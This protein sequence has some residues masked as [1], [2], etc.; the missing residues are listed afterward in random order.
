MNGRR[1]VV[2]GANTGL[3]LATAS[4]LAGSGVVVVLAGRN[5]GKLEA[6]AET[7]RRRTPAAQLSVGLLDLA[8]LSSVG[9]FAARQRDAGPLD[10]LV[11]NAGLMLVPHRE[12]TADGFELQMGVNHLG[13]FALTRELWPALS[14][15][16]G[17]VVSLSSI[18][19]RMAG[20]FDPGMGEIGPYAPFANYA[21]SKLACLMFALELHRRSSAAPG[22]R[23]TSVAAHPGYVATTLFTRAEHPSLSDRLS[24]LF[25]PVVGSRP[26][27]GARSQLRAATDPSLTGGEFIG[28]R[29]LVRGRPHRATPS[30]DALD[31]QAAA[32]L[33]EISAEKTGGDFS[34]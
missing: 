7:I 33:W 31:R 16:S 8:D 13:H 22:N 5:A 24:R 2:T 1:A 21:R 19:H 34:F 10:L 32:M 17:R 9:A 25:T 28:P 14:A 3:G 11:N 29:F 26:A 12:Y 30:A 23:V 4:A 18:A 20:P 6:A 27:H 15:A